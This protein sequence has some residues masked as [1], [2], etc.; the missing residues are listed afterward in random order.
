MGHIVA[1]WRGRCMGC[2][3]STKDL[4]VVCISVSSQNKH[5]DLFYF[6]YCHM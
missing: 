4:R 5:F 3:L 6:G 1:S 2:R